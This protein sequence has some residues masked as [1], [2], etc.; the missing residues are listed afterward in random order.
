MEVKTNYETVL[1]KYLLG[2][3]SPAERRQIE[4]WLMTDDEAYFLLE[5]AE[6]DLI[7]ESLQQGLTEAEMAQFDKLFLAAPERQR[8]LQFRSSFRR[9]VEGYTPVKPKR[10]RFFDMSFYRPAFV[11]AL[12]A[13][14]AIAVAVSG[15]S[16]LRIAGLQ[17]ELAETLADRDRLQQQIASPATASTPSNISGQSAAVILSLMPGAIRSRGGQDTAPTAELNG[18]TVVRIS[19]A[20][21]QDDYKTYRAYLVYPDDTEVLVGNNLRSNQGKAVALAIPTGLLSAAQYSIRLEGISNSPVPD[22]IDRY[23]FRITRR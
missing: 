4:S 16:L 20:L 12:S 7:D 13:V 11:Y 22:T 15:W 17:R 10:K 6:D 14:L 18:D 1:R 2:Q 21:L 9:A 23:S 8:K 5:A 3:V 19:L